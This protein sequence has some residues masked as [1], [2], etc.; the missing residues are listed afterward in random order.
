MNENN[1]KFFL[2][3][4]MLT[5]IFF[6]WWVN[7]SIYMWSCDSWVWPS[8]APEAGDGGEAV[9]G[10]TEIDWSQP[11]AQNAAGNWVSNFAISFFL[12]P[13]FSLFFSCYILARCFY[14]FMINLDWKVS[15]FI[16]YFSFPYRS[17]NLE[18]NEFYDELSFWHT[19]C[20]SRSFTSHFLRKRTRTWIW[21]G[22][23]MT[24]SPVTSNNIRSIY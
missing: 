17:V 7:L 23:L 15:Y 6:V 18:T 2:K 16:E 5:H 14:H 22:S 1:T 21:I 8:G 9:G 19:S 13:H 11:L 20:L 24:P 12:L 4:P 10:V 3:N